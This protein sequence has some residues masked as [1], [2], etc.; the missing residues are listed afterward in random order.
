[1]GSSE[2]TLRKKKYLSKEEIEVDV[3]RNIFLLPIFKKI[4]NSDGLLTTNE[5]NAI[6]YGLINPKIRKKIIQI[7]G[8]KT[9]KLNLEDLCYFYSLLNTTSYEAKLNFLLDFI[10]IKKD[11]LPKEK[12]IHKVQKYFIGSSLLQSILLDPKLLEKSKQDRDTVYKFIVSNKL[13]EIKKYPL[14]IN[15][16]MGPS[17][18][19]EDDI[20]SRDVLLLNSNTKAN[21]SREINPNMLD[22]FSGK[23]RQGINIS[24]S[25][26]LRPIKLTMV[27]LLYHYLKKC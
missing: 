17:Q 26:N 21:N 27:F 15:E 9:D 2:S 6:T 23:K 25:L 18:D 24:N 3:S 1:M 10:F 11:K 22:Y 20:N 4:K 12:Y 19:N 5:L 16:N 7:C 8:S 14:Y 13:E